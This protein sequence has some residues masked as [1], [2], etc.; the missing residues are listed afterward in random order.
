MRGLI[1]PTITAA[2]LLAVSAE[3][4]DQ[5][6]GFDGFKLWNS[7]KPVR[8]VVEDL[9]DDAG[10]IGLRKEDIETAVR[11]RLRGARVYDGNA[12]PYLYVNVNVVSHAFS[13]GVEFRR[14]AEVVMPSWLKPEGMDHLIGI[15]TTWHSG[16]TG[17]HGAQSGFI[18]SSLAPHI[19][20]F[21]DEY[22]RVNDTACRKS[23]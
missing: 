16:S 17:T 8:L 20:E 6:T 23:N 7:C 22:L 12:S 10:K 3:A 1:L 9:P 2:L 18:L 5:V 13:T 15:A 11:S 21:I 14:T 4:A 19:D